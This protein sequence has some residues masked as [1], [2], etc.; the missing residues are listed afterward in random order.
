MTAVKHQQKGGN[1]KARSSRRVADHEELVTAAGVLELPKEKSI[2]LRLTTAQKEPLAVAAAA[3][4][5]SLS[6]WI[7]SV[8]VREASEILSTQE[9]PAT[10]GGLKDKSFLLRLTAAQKELLAAAAAVKEGPLS[11]W[12]VSV[13][14]GE[15][16]RRIK[17]RKK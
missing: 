9:Q 3:A 16:R 8:A 12:I 1:R 7:I 5:V 11:T 15:A 14:L 6:T 13:A 4:G 17:T 10:V 2:L